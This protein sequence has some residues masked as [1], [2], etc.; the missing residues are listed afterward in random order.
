VLKLQI[1]SI[2]LIF[3]SAVFAQNTLEYYLNHSL[4]N[5]PEISAIKS[6]IKSNSLDSFINIASNR[7][8][9]YFTDTAMYAPFINGY[10]FDSAITNGGNLSALLG[11]SYTV[12][13]GPNPS[14]QNRQISFENQFLYD[15]L[16]IA[17]QDLI[18]TIT[19]LYLTAWGDLIQWKNAGKILELYSDEDPLLKKLIQKGVYLQTDYL[20][21]LI[22]YKQQQTTYIKSFS[23]YKS[24]LSSLNSTCG[25]IDTSTVELTDP[26]LR[27]CKLPDTSNSVFFTR[28][29]KDS[30]RIATE[31][32]LLKQSYIPVLNVGALAGFNSSFE[33]LSSKHIGTSAG[34]TFTVPIYDGGQYK[35]KKQKIDIEEYNIQREKNF[36]KSQYLQ[37]IAYLKE[38]LDISAKL[39]DQSSNQLNLHET[40]IDADRKLL[41]SGEIRITDFVSTISS[42]LDAQNNTAQD[43]V[44][45]YQIINELNY[46]SR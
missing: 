39:I 26:A 3:N 15:S 35:Y 41:S 30:L 1:L 4:C 27:L 17:Y 7:P 19:A 37:Q 32:I 21:F 31:R 8:Q 38:Q 33:P 45:R 16:I 25:I 13:G 14:V 42:F 24:D 36:F 44:N 12:I 2:L 40:L 22:S 9:V 29:I 43:I 46:W 10:G 20:S 5:S 18:K 23:K 34:I 6:K 11:V 28:F